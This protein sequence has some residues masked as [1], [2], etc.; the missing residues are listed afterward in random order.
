MR[1][2][3]SAERLRAPLAE[4]TA[5]AP[6]GSA[7][8]DDVH[9]DAPSTSG[10]PPSFPGGGLRG[11]LRA[12]R[13][14][15]SGPRL[16]RLLLFTSLREFKP[17]E[18]FLVELY[19]SRGLGAGTL[20]N[21]VF[22]AWTHARL[23]ALVFVCA[24][25][26]RFGCRRA[27]ILGTACGMVTVGMTAAFALFARA[28]NADAPTVLGVPALAW[29]RASQVSAAVAFASHQ[30]FLGIAFS[31]P[32]ADASFDEA[33]ASR[34]TRGEAVTR[35][36][37][38]VAHGVKAATLLATCVSALL[39][40][41]LARFGAPLASLLALT[42]AT[43]TGS[44]LVAR[45]FEKDISISGE[46]ALPR[47]L[48]R[49]SHAVDEGNEGNRLLGSASGSEAV[50]QERTSVVGSNRRR[51]AK[52]T[53][54]LFF[55][56]A[57]A[58]FRASYLASRAIVADPSV[59]AWCLWSVASAPTHAFVAANWQT[60]VTETPGCEE[61]RGDETG[62]KKKTFAFGAWLAAQ[63]AAA[64]LATLAFGAV[65]YGALVRSGPGDE[66][67]TKRRRDRSSPPNASRE[68]GGGG[69]GVGRAASRRDDDDD[70]ARD[71]TEAAS[72][73]SSSR[74]VAFR[75]GF[76]NPERS[77]FAASASLGASAC[78]LLGASLAATRTSAA[79]F[80]TAFVCVF[81][82]VS[83]VC[84]AAVG[85]EA[86]RAVTSERTTNSL[87]EAVPR[88]TS[89]AFVFASL[90]ACGY[91]VDVSTQ[92]VTDLLSLDVRRRFEARA[93]F[94]AFAAG[95][96]LVYLCA[97]FAFRAKTPASLSVTGEAESAAATRAS[98]ADDPSARLLVAEDEA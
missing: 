59:A 12:S 10:R 74:N 22:P 32:S 21:D 26:A 55:F 98:D 62:A 97:R 82:A 51:F 68:T 86:C 95:A 57:R 43:Q 54:R 18:P 45:A 1:A 49:T 85:L 93:A 8:G 41:A 13:D 53:P 83:S 29:A 28:M 78:F 92:G 23:P 30:A 33:S 63:R 56:G 14:P 80:V 40:Q 39:G 7:S 81:E 17:S 24:V 73:V 88:A 42:F 87:A 67:D 71:A 61:T 34:G 64:C 44:L 46:E 6:A 20:T 38:A 96:F 9:D 77:L 2:G 19:E 37:P 25:A 60:L 47:T 58:F 94:A 72:S 66:Q 48:P 15:S 3:A 90:S 79:L 16:R 35:T 89:L 91:A 65:A 27:V 70:E 84:A 76:V 36:F 75:S 4:L 31:H 69:T 5:D 52:R 50:F 11:I